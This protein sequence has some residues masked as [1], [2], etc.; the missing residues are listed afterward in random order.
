M[1]QAI[2]LTSSAAPADQSSSKIITAAAQDRA[3]LE[4]HEA[5]YAKG[6][7]NRDR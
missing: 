3:C 2:A 1:T 4:M 7:A 5:E 6:G